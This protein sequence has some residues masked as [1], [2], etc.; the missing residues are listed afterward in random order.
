MLRVE[1]VFSNY[2]CPR[3]K[4]DVDVRID[5]LRDAET[6]RVLSQKFECDEAGTCCLNESA[7]LE[8]LPECPHPDARSLPTRR[9]NAAGTQG[10][11]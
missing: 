5:R 4:R 9:E 3:M 6:N 10:T 1:T 8:S 11:P 7:S 2:S